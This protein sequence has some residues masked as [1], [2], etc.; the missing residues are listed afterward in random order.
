MPAI[1]RIRDER[2]KECG[3]ASS[4]EREHLLGGAG[5]KAPPGWTITTGHIIFDV[6][7]QDGLHSEGKMGEGWPQDS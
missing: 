3:G 4:K 1:G 5:H 7:S 2:N 6:K